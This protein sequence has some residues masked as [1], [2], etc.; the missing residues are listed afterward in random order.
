MAS[1]AMLKSM[2]AANAGLAREPGSKFRRKARDPRPAR[3]LNGRCRRSDSCSNPPPL[4]CLTC[5]VN[6]AAADSRDSGGMYSR[7][8]GGVVFPREAVG[9]GDDSGDSSSCD[10]S[11]SGGSV[12]PN[13][14]TGPVGD[15][16]AGAYIRTI[17]PFSYGVFFENQP[18]ATLPAAQV[19][20]TDQL[21]PTKVDLTTVTLGT[22][23]FGG[24]VINLP[25]GTNNFNTTYSIN[26]SL[27]VRIQGSLNPGTGLLKWTFTSLDPG[28]GL[29]PSDPTVGFLPPDTDGIKGQGSVSFTIKPMSAL[30]TGTQIT[31]QATVVFDAN[32]PI[33]TP[34]WLN[35]I[36][37]TAP[38]SAVGTLPA[39]ETTATFPVSWAGSDIG[40][41]IAFYNISVSDNSGPFTAWLSQT[42]AA[43]ANYSGQPGHAY[44]FYSI[45]TDR[46]GNVQAAKSVA[47]A[48]TTVSPNAVGVLPSISPNGVVPISSTSSIIQSGEWASIYG[49]NLAGGTAYWAGDFP[50]SLGGT[51]VT[52]DGK[53]AYLS[54]VSPGQIDIQV[55][56]DTVTGTVPVVVTT[57]VGS[58][59][60]SVTLAPFGPSFFL[61]DGIHVAGIIPRSDGAYD[62]LGPTGTSL[63]YPT[64]AAKAGDVVELYGTGFG[65]TNPGVS[66]GQVFSGAAP[67]TNPVT[68]SIN[69]VTVS[70]S[71][72]GLSGAGLYQLNLTIPPGLGTGDVSLQASVG[73]VLTPTGIV[74]SLQ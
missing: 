22:I 34:T 51:S 49:S 56:D 54:F 61:L 41:G 20:V 52:I 57:A 10:G 72:A 27:S 66:A 44:G 74:I 35:T 60:S 45:A 23:S 25:S 46:A 13:A 7:V 8:N 43:A 32:A 37:V 28:T 59:T 58:G 39:V 53:A 63:G 4:S 70:P 26:S 21:D 42:T 31:N 16:S 6:D 1:V 15:G 62:I 38:A 14:K 36:D 40:S 2:V 33:N 5:F 69:N 18:S 67:T 12:D 17:S 11:S 65:P 19:V 55:P 30:I 48:T 68:L 3:P 24:N 29:P 47:D 73:G 71:F 9:P 50:T 64:V